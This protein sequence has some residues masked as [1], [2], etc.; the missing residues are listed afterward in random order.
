VHRF[1]VKNAPEIGRQ[2]GWLCFDP[3]ERLRHSPYPLLDLGREREGKKGK[4]IKVG[5]EIA[6]N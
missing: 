2:A 4:E 1:G 5:G 3:L 6:P